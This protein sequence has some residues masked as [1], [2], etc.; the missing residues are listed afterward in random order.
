MP[1]ASN[2]LLMPN[3]NP[4]KKSDLLYVLCIEDPD[5]WTQ[6]IEG[7]YRSFEDAS[8]I[9]IKHFK[10]LSESHGM[11]GPLHNSENHRYWSFSSDSL[12][13]T[14]TEVMFE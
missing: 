7:I 8:E 3:A 14:I 2:D 9:A 11:W 1:M 5:T 13:A 4:S 12:I 6:E 10:L